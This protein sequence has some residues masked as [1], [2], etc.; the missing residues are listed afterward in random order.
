MLLKMISLINFTVTNQQCDFGINKKI[1]CRVIVEET[2][3]SNSL[4][5]WKDGRRVCCLLYDYIYLQGVP[6]LQYLKEFFK[7]I[8]L[9]RTDYENLLPI[10]IGIINNKH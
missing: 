3:G 9:G 8:V 7:Q 2:C 10:T 6:V 4:M 5:K 1:L